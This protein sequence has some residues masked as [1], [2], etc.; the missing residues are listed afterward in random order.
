MIDNSYDLIPPIC[1]PSTLNH[2]SDYG[3]EKVEFANINNLSTHGE[4]GYMDFSCE[5]QAYIEA[6]ANYILKVTT[7]SQNPHDTRAWI[8]YNN[9]G[10][11]ENDE[12]VM[13]QLNTK[14]P[15]ENIQ[16]PETI[17]YDTSFRL[18]ISSDLVGS[19]NGP[20]DNVTAGQVEDYGIFASLCP[21]PE[22]I[23]IGQVTNNSVELIWSEST[24]ETSWNVQYGPEGFNPQDQTGIIISNI[25]THNYYVTGLEESVN[26]A[27]YVQS[28]CAT[29]SSNW[30]GPH[31]TST[32]SLE[33]E[34][35]NISV[36]TFPNPN[37]GVFQI[38][39]SINFNKIEIFNLLG[40]KTKDYYSKNSNSLFLSI[41]NMPPGIYFIKIY[42]EN[43]EL[44]EK[45]TY[46]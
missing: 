40:E 11:F 42:F 13:E 38:Q 25:Y 44:T 45:I 27:F 35:D 28:N 19:D 4:E 43:R 6:G 5:N 9:N 32:T 3:I 46:N 8:D 24:S 41:E 22:D 17:I 16:I 37:N 33:N 20:C 14:D 31:N 2:F 26:Y 36:K 29:S 34:I 15:E 10:E 21:F 39:S 23:T 12:L 1:N 7:G 30:M 18:R